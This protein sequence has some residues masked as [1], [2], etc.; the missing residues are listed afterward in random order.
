MATIDTTELKSRVDLL[1]LVGAYTTLRGG[2]NTRHGPCPWC[3]GK[4]RF[5]VKRAEQVCACNQC[6]GTSAGDWMDAIGF[7]RRN[8]GLDFRDACEWLTRWAGGELPTVD[9]PRRAPRRQAPPVYAPEPPSA[10]WQSSAWQVVDSCVRSL[11]SDDGERART[12]LH[13]RGLNDDTL[14]AWRIG[15]HQGPPGKG[16]EIAGLYVR[17]GITI[18]W[19]CDGELWGINVRLPV[20]VNGDK[21]LSVGGSHKAGVLV[22]LDHTDGHEQAMV[23]EGEFDAALV[24]QECGEL[25]DALTLGSASSNL[26]DRWIERLL[27]YRRFWI[28]TDDD[29]D[30]WKAAARWEA[31]TG[32]RGRRVYLP[33]GKDVTEAWQNGENL[34]AWAALLMEGTA[35]LVNEGMAK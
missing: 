13:G 29:A 22:G 21:Y 3:G 30:G 7:V 11:W 24:W 18:P 9:G 20:L 28:A 12:W 27:G 26:S 25:L 15:Y 35:A 16:K 2:G 10:A 5:A 6:T 34:R 23:V 1:T 32:D 19:V 14:R 17:H 31:W 33:A 8:G 4:D